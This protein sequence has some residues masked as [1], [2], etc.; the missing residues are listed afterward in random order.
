MSNIHDITVIAG[1]SGVGKTFI[2]EKLASEF[3]SY[4]HLSAGSLIKKK[5]GKFGS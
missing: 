2:I 1:L 4:F 3:D 5:A